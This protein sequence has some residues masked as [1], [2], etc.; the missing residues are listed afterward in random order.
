MVVATPCTPFAGLVE[1]PEGRPLADARVRVTVPDG[2][3]ERLGVPLDQSGDMTWEVRSAADG[4]FVLEDLP[5]LPEL[6]FEVRRAG[7]GLATP[8][9]ETLRQTAGVVVL[10]PSELAAES[11]RPAPGADTVTGSVRVSDGSPAVGARIWA[12]PETLRAGRLPG[13]V[14]TDGAGR[15]ELPSFPEGELRLV[16]IAADSLQWLQYRGSKRHDLELT[17]PATT[18]VPIRG[19]LVDA[20]GEGV[21]GVRV[22]LQR[23]VDSG[24]DLVAETLRSV[25]RPGAGSEHGFAGTTARS[26][27]GM[28][29]GFQAQGPRAV[30]D[31]DG[32]FALPPVARSGLQLRLW[33]ERILEQMVSVEPTGELRI[34]VEEKTHLQ[35][36][37]ESGLT[38]DAVLFLDSEGRALGARVAAG[39][40]LRS[41]PRSLPIREGRTEF[42]LVSPRTT[43]LVLLEG[44]RE[45]FR[46]P[47]TLVP[48]ES[49]T[50]HL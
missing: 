25:W 30:T 2:L 19:R 3:R 39:P 48:G 22:Q 33:S 17:F 16:A 23:P 36:V 34:E 38:A 15:F 12:F 29:I 40:V 21:G 13:G 32:R 8:D 10:T 44:D 37:L 9:L 27:S 35:V 11:P 31:A 20:R 7:Y 42:A 18:L 43:T 50:L 49:R 14:E 24:Q 47:I 4:R 5:M 46:I 45:V 28:R 1:D 41:Y 6:S 26:G